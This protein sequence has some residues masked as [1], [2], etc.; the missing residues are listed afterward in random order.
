MKRLFFFLF[1]IIFSYIN[2]SY[3]KNIRTDFHKL[4]ILF[5]SVILL[6]GQIFFYENNQD[7]TA[8]IKT[9]YNIENYIKAS[10]IEKKLVSNFEDI[11]IFDKKNNLNIFFDS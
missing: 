10:E 9:R 5:D 7:T 4:H 3:S 2:S 1:L 6:D 8:L 11:F